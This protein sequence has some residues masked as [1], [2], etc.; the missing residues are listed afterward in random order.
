MQVLEQKQRIPPMRKQRPPSKLFSD[1]NTLPFA[2]VMG[3]GCLSSYW[4]SCH[5]QSTVGAFLSI[6]RKYIIPSPYLAR[7]AKMR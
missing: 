5:P 7:L 6:C 1:F 2:S 4:C 3:M